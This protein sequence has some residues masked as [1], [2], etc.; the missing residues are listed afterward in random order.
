MAIE[1]EGRD[2]IFHERVLMLHK[3]GYRGFSLSGIKKK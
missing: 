3:N 2:N 1:E